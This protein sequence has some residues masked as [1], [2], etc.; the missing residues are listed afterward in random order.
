MTTFSLGSEA[1]LCPA[2]VRRFVEAPFRVADAGIERMP[3]EEGIPRGLAVGIWSP[4]EVM[5][6]A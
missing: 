6:Y 4:G 3:F 2:L 1:L 5:L